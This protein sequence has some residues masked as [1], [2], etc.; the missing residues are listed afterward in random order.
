[1]EVTNIS[2]KVQLNKAFR[3]NAPEM[4]IDDRIHQEEKGSDS[5]KLLLSAG[6]LAS[7][8][9]AGVAL[10][11][12]KNFKKEIQEI[13]NKLQDSE[14]VAEELKSKLK[15]AEDKAVKVQEAAP[16]AKTAEKS[17]DIHGLEEQNNVLTNEN[18]LLRSQIEELKKN[19][20]EKTK[21][22]FEKVKKVFT[23]NTDEKVQTAQVEKTP[24]KP[25]TPEEAL[26]A[27][28]NLSKREQKQIIAQ[29]KKLLK[30]KLKI[31][32][33]KAKAPVN[34]KEQ[35][36]IKSSAA[37]NDIFNMRAVVE[38][39]R[40]NAGQTKD[41][42]DSGIKKFLG[43]IKA[44]WQEAKKKRLEKKQEKALRKEAEK[45]E[46]KAQEAAKEAELKNTLPA[47]APVSE[48]IP[49]NI[50]QEDVE[51]V[52]PDKKQ[53]AKKSF[54][55]NIKTKYQTMKANRAAR[56]QE[57]ALRKETERAEK[58][59]QEAAKQEEFI[60]G[61]NDIQQQNTPKKE[62]KFKKFWRELFADE[63]DE[64]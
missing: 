22:F 3:A 27:F 64:C 30:E 42:A 5:S 8:G 44:K 33:K 15:E 45:A 55:E 10:Y 61:N 29:L 58:E 7:L 31:M 39:T 48:V 1:M 62:S 35:H 23:K 21:S 50:P 13:K 16:A 59:A 46:K 36:V 4:M 47:K 52:S 37:D 14:K 34:I 18:N 60:N 43:D 24:E 6:I 57:K 11:K 54:I 19:T 28:N 32:Q 53:V 12:N 63:E 56:K 25:V 9:V 38:N 51:Q 40:K 26:Q 20:K 41:N 17:A 2:P 49:E